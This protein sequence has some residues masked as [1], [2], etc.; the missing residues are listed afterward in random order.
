LSLFLL[1]LNLS[2]SLLGFFINLSLNLN[3]FFLFSVF[4]AL[5]LFVPCA[6]CPPKL[7]SEGWMRFALLLFLNLNLSLSLS[8][9]P[10]S[11]FFFCNI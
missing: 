7:D 10:I 2:L 4:T 9:F 1:S 5:Y 6:T 11:Y 3:L 8:L